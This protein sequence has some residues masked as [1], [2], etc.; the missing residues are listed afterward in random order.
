[1]ASAT[2]IP[3]QAIVPPEESVGEDEPLLGRP[4]DASQKE[5]RPLYQNLIIGKFTKSPDSDKDVSNSHPG[6]AVL[7][8]AGVLLLVA[9]V[10]ANIFLGPLILFSAHPLLNS[11]GLLGITESILVLQPTHTPTQKSRGTLVHAAVNGFAVDAFIAAL[12]IIEVNKFAHAGTHFDSPH[13]ILGLITYVL[14]LVQALVGFTLYF[15]PRVH[16][17]VDAAKSRYKWHRASGYVIL[18]FLLAT[19]IAATQT[20]YNK[21]TLGINVWAIVVSAALILLGIVPRIK[22]QKFGF[23]SRQSDVSTHVE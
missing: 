5:G 6:T 23:G 7:A 2:G 16:G 18:G 3:D 13:A 19:T 9:S 15:Y 12:V 21:T 1:M 20:T 4:G 14:L 10:W 8:Q 22:K 11:A 17:G